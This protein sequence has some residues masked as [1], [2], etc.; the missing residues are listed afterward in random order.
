[1]REDETTAVDK[2]SS[3][4]SE[5]EVRPFGFFHS[6]T[7]PIYYA[8]VEEFYSP[9]TPKSLKARRLPTEYSLPKFDFQY[10]ERHTYVRTVFLFISRTQLEIIK[11]S[12]NNE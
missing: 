9:G 10:V 8:Q 6:S 5:E 2:E 12:R 4:E 7:L 11:E 1:M 3:Q